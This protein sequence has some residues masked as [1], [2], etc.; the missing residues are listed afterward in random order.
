MSADRYALDLIVLVPGKDDS[1][2][3]EGLLTRHNSLRI[4]QFEYEINIHP[5]KDAGC[6]KVGVDFLRSQTKRVKHA[7]I[8]FDH[9]GSGVEDKAVD[10]IEQE[11]RYK[12]NISGWEDRADVLV[13]EPEIER[14]IW[15]DSPH[16]DEELGWKEKRPNLRTW[17]TGK[18]Y[19]VNNDVK[20]NKPK[21]AMEQALRTAQ[22]PRTSDIYFQL[23]SKVTLTQCI[24]P[25]FNKL[26]SIL[27]KWFGVS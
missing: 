21:E 22:I 12:L 1:K 2:A 23:A 13:I 15:S 8:V 19:I 7:L 3:I 10:E 4:R 5:Q 14:W 24:D 17:L 26:K 18:N 9:E 6:Y 27:T 11:L 25:S 16:V 20:P